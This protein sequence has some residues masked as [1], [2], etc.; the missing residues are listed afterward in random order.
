MYIVSENKDINKFESN[1]KKTN[2]KKV[3]EDY[4]T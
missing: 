3:L 4:E 2:E 1:D